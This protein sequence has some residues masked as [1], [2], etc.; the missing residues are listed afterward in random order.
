M[1]GAC[2]AFDE[3][4][5]VHPSLSCVWSDAARD[6]GCEQRRVLDAEWTKRNAVERIELFAHRT[7]P[8]RGAL[9][10]LAALATVARAERERKSARMVAGIGV[11]KPA[12]IV[13]GRWLL[14]VA[15]GNGYANTARFIAVD[16]TTDGPAT[17]IPVTTFDDPDEA[18]DAAKETV[19]QK[20][21]D[22]S[23][24]QQ[25]T[26]IDDAFTTATSSVVREKTL[27]VVAVV[28]TDSGHRALFWIGGDAATSNV[29]ALRVASD[30]P[31]YMHCDRFAVPAS[32]SRIVLATP[33]LAKLHVES[34][35]TMHQGAIDDEAQS[36]FCARSATVTWSGGF[37][38]AWEP[39]VC[40]KEARR[41][42]IGARGKL[43]TADVPH[44]TPR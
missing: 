13:A 12:G 25:F 26:P 41:V 34:V 6:Y 2:T 40:A 16:L 4:Y 32:A 37:R 24:A 33:F 22:D 43:S 27:H 42:V 10:S 36:E 9:A 31:E 8:P 3:I 29:D 30:A 20:S 44:E 1:G 14:F 18:T 23:V 28:L 19:D 21:R 17:V 11:L 7:H 39:K 5:S 35:W 15:T 38:V